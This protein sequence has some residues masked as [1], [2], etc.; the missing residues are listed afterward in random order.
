MNI[1]TLEQRHKTLTITLTG[2][3]II[4]LLR[5]SGKLEAPYDFIATSAQFQVPRGG[6][7]SGMQLD[8]DNASP[9]IVTLTR[10]WITK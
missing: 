4:D 10:T 2:Q 1:E 8:V 5:L 7:Y 9:I 6:D 3:D